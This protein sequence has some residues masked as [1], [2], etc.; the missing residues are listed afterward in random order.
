MRGFVDT[1]PL[2]GTLDAVFAPAADGTIPGIGRN[3]EAGRLAAL[4]IVTIS[5]SEGRSVAWVQ[6]Q[7]ITDWERPFRESRQ[8]PI[9]VDH[10]M[11][12][13]ALPFLF[14]AVR[15]E[16]G[17]YGDGGIRLVTPLSPAVHLGARRILA[18]S[19]RYG[20]KPA[21]SAA[22]ETPRYPPPA[23][24]AG[25]LLDAV[26]LDDLDRD[27][28]H[29]VRLNLLLA[30]LPEEK[31]RGL[32]VVDLVLIRP[33]QDIGR[34]AGAFE[35]RLPRPLRHLF[36]GTGTRQIAN[37]DLLSLL[38]FQPEYLK[39]LLEIGEADFEARAADVDALIGQ[40]GG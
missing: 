32:N 17:W 28:Q 26:F 39:R 24:I 6:G 2:R 3:L 37:Q 33:S 19:T 40:P 36:G 35:P 12:S 30:D 15:V 4:A 27:A 5:Y 13:A 22:E 38:M 25:Q 21:A 34:L 16:G 31:R 14:P 20:R 23:Q 11:G 18:F 10:V 8:R 29:L 1:A 7:H 9:T